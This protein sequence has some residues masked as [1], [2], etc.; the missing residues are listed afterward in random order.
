MS[1]MTFLRFGA[2]LWGD[3]K[4]RFADLERGGHEQHSL[5]GFDAGL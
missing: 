4:T 5:L 1:V 3:V 2:I